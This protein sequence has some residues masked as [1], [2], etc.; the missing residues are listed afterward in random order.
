MCCKTILFI[1][2][3]ILPSN[4]AEFVYSP[5]GKAIEKQAKTNEDQWYKQ[6]KA[7]EDNEKT[8]NNKKT[9]RK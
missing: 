8:L 4:Q 6:I 1:S 5:L 2:E 9:T 7:I 3:D